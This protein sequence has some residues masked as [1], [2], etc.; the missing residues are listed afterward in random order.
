MKT[1]R[2]P[3]FLLQFF[4]IALIFGVAE[5][6]SSNLTDSLKR[7][8]AKAT[9][10]STRVRLL[11]RIAWN[12][13]Y[14]DLD[15]G[16]HYAKKELVLANKINNMFYI[17]KSYNTIGTI[18]VDKGNYKEATLA[19][20]NAIKYYEKTE[21]KSGTGYVYANMS[22]I[23]QRRGN[24]DV[25][26]EYLHKAYAIFNTHQ[27]EKGIA[28]VS[29]N[30]AMY[31]IEKS[32]FDSAAYYINISL[33]LSSKNKWNHYIANN[34]AVLGQ[35]EDEKGNKSL[36]KKYFAE[37]KK[38]FE[39]MESYYD[40]C[41]IIQTEAD[42]E[43]DAKNYSA[44]IPLLLVAKNYATEI[45]LPDDMRMINENL[46]LCYEKI[47]DL[48]NALSYYKAYSKLKDSLRNEENMKQVNELQ[49]KMKK[50]D[51]KKQ[52]A[53]LKKDKSIQDLE[54]QTQKD[55]IAKQNMFL[56][57]AIGFTIL[58]T[59]LVILLF[60]GNKTKQKNNKLL[61][62]QKEIIEEKNK[63]IVDSINYAKR[64]QEAILP[65][66]KQIINSFKESAILYL[67]KD[68]VAG[69]FYFLEKVNDHL[70]FAACDCTGHGVPGAMVSVVC[71]NAL[72]RA[73]KEFQ[74]TD[75]GKILDKVRELVIETFDKNENEVRD[76][77]D[78]SLCSIHTKT[79]KMYWAG[80]HNPIW[81]ISEDKSIKEIKGDKQ[82]IGKFDEARAFQT[83]EINY[84][85]NDLIVLVTD[86]YSDQFGG[87]KGKKLK[88]SNF[89]SILTEKSNLH[90][91]EIKKQLDLQFQDWK[92]D[93]EQVDDV[94]VFM[95]RI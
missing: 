33:K 95:V 77:M 27:D 18:Y 3:I 81:I 83:H 82:P 86:G 8:L 51:L 47:G 90:P 34:L 61:S 54:N 85:S 40:L 50:S 15:S 89:K 88:D 49:M 87:D 94:C 31:H 38:I 92:G 55:E 48:G 2:L 70:I 10:D 36:S 30:I 28:G 6:K 44:A 80:A 74:L 24:L 75:P 22:N 45:G 23:E 93:L 52:N 72:N 21:V 43:I 59:I 53:L 4:I 66:Q 91:E 46:S 39:E 11:D 62:H 16:L 29:H 12:I 37:S 19:F 5:V 41:H 69:D 25:M 1:P 64:L 13:S 68:I 42:I 58:F 63:E 76:G 7:E 84:N 20:E 78:I 56:T 17:A 9:V 32:D 57:I 71:A 26:L 79:K 35:L 60:I 73:V 14:E 67:P 65:S